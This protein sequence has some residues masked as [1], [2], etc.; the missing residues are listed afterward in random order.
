MKVS[1]NQRMKKH[2]SLFLLSMLFAS[3]A[4]LRAQSTAFTYQGR[5]T[6]GGALANGLYDFRLFAYNADAGGSQVGP[7]QLFEDVPVTNGVFVVYPDF[8]AGVFNGQPRWIEV[9][10]RPGASTG[11]YTTLSPR[12]PVLATPVAQVANSV[13]ALAAG[14]VGS[15]QLA[16][17]AVGTP[18]LADGSVTTVK[19]ADGAV[20][21]AKLAPSSVGTPQLADA[22]ATTAKLADASV[23]T[24]KLANGAVT[25]ANLAPN[26]VGT[27]QLADGGITA[28]KLAPSVAAGLGGTPSGA[29]IAAFDA[30]APS[31]MTNGYVQVPSLS[32]SVGGWQEISERNA[33]TN[34]YNSDYGSV[35]TGTELVVGGEAMG[36]PTRFA[37]TRFNPATGLWSPA[38]TNG[39][40]RFDSIGARYV[41]MVLGG[42]E[43]FVIGRT[44]TFA[45]TNSTGGIY[46]L[47][48]GTWRDIPTNGAAQIYDDEA[49][50]VAH[51]F[52]TGSELLAA[53]TPEMGVFGVAIFNP[54]TNGWRVANTNGYS[55]VSPNSAIMA[56][57]GTELLVYGS[58]ITNFSSM[59]G[60]LYRPDTGVW[61]SATT[62]GG[63]VFSSG[64][65]SR[66]K[67]LWTG[68]EI[69]TLIPSGASE[70]SRFFAFSPVLNSWRA[71]STNGMPTLGGPTPTTS[72]NLFWTGAEVG[73]VLRTGS[74]TTSPYKTVVGLYHPANDTWRSFT[75]SDPTIASLGATAD[76][77]VGVVPVWNNTEAFAYLPTPT[78]GITV[79]SKVFR[80]TPPRTLYFYQKP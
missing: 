16:P 74:G 29:L 8:G 46:N 10:V 14:S 45:N 56:W 12:Q 43:V 36:P 15:A 49:A 9:G 26:S 33:Q 80:F 64:P 30:N 51:L 68:S 23:T 4:V 40:P 27:G 65:T 38:A 20:A 58:S 3:G 41:K 70:P 2:L 44:D 42:S 48:N 1:P 53:G 72:P 57:T 28:A 59:A 39:E 32:T 24:A 50:R 17:G 47:T 35:W 55:P 6:D 37:L 76:Y 5:L 52:W 60:S 71:C 7:T 25:A 75:T 34:Y 73:M 77:S 69:I 21:T 67:P 19:L 13:L 11:I 18:Q 79:I 66:K 62:N 31:L 63:P 61:R 54:A 78:D 22:S